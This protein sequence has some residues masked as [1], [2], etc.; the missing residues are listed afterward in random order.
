MR[1]IHNL[2]PQLSAASS[3]TP[4]LSR[5]VS[6]LSAGQEGK[7]ILDD[8]SL[9][10]HFSLSN[11][12][13]HCIT[14]TSLSA[15]ELAATHP[16]TAFVHSFPGGV[17]TN[18]LRDFNPVV[19][20]LVSG[21][22][23]VLKALPTSALG[24]VPVEESGE[25]HVYAA[26]SGLFQPRTAVKNEDVA[27]GADGVTGSGAYLLHWDSSA[28]T[29]KLPLIQEYLANGVEKKVLE[30]TVEVFDKIC[31]SREAKY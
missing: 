6:V 28:Q 21:L 17:D 13:T 10:T 20:G 11:A 30:H 15:I 14:M 25:R 8:L 24:L 7:L 18:I 23:K 29:T 16:S 2:L 31:N 27:I 9:K 26:T 1:F 3:S 22:V 19:R 12:A 4:N 5:V